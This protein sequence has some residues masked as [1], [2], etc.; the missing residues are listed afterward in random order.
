MS[1]HF[2]R[3]HLV[4]NKFQLGLIVTGYFAIVGSSRV[5]LVNQNLIFEFS[6][7]DDGSRAS[8]LAQS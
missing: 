3:I 2:C 8:T 7:H 1:L 5:P 6:N 4:L